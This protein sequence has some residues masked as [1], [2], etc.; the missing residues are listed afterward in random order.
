ML[1]SKI[2]SLVATISLLS[3][4]TGCSSIRTTPIN[5]HP[6]QADD[7][8]GSGEPVEIQGWVDR[9]GEEHEWKGTVQAV[10]ADSLEFKRSLAPR[11]SANAPAPREPYT[12]PPSEMLRLSQ[13]DV[14]SIVS[15]EAEGRRGF[16]L[17]LAIVA[18]I[19][20]LTIVAIMTI[21]T[22]PP[23]WLGIEY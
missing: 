11:R 15:L 3:T 6:A 2:T 8:L 21:D 17:G 23:S 12:G 14:A 9:A 16:L 18:G 1:R 7:L 5:D 10:A 22:D 20:V 19:T 4:L 13:A